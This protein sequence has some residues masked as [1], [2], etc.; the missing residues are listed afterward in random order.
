MNLTLDP[1][2]PVIGSDGRH[3][4]LS[5]KALFQ[6]ADTICDLAVQPHEK[7]ALMRLLIC[8]AQAALDGPSDRT[9]WS[10]SR[11]A[12]QGAANRYLEKWSTS[13][14]LFGNGPRFLQVPQLRLINDKKPK[15]SATKLD[16]TLASGNN[17]TVFDNAA[18]AARAVSPERLALTILAFQCFA[19][20]G[21]IGVA[22]WGDDE[23]PG[24]GTCNHAP[25]TPS[26]MLHTYIRGD[27]LLDTVHLNL[28]TRDEVA[29]LWP[30]G[31]GRP[32]W[33]MPVNAADDKKAIDNATGSYLGRLV[34][35]SRTIQLE[36]DGIHIILA[37]ALDYSQ[38][39]PSREA[40]STMVTKEGNRF[41][42]GAFLGRSIWRQLHMMTV[43]PRPGT[44]PI[45]G[46]LALRN[47][48]SN[49]G[50]TLWTGALVTDKAKIED[51]VEACYEIPPGMFTDAGRKLYEDGINLADQWEAALFHSLKEYADALKLKTGANIQAKRHFWTI[52]ETHVPTLLQLADSPDRVPDIKASK[53]ADLARDAAYA[54][55]ALVC[56]RLNSR[57]TQAF[58]F[59]LRRLSIS[60]PK[61]RTPA[62]IPA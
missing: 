47:L 43:K 30:M 7:I 14:E 27:T 4:D 54:S 59:G 37:N 33:E 39:E 26:A 18:R 2:I 50:C 17:A 21:R 57:Q 20:C 52:L 22:L 15:T 44:D 38:P 46:P 45:C 19:T 53:W 61:R 3:Q 12:I 13:F 1:W 8:I 9:A 56:S 58:A 16:L 42:M 24:K 41:P 40:A 6:S 10:W 48:A 55:Y 35:L 62:P 23:T 29:T 60:K 25:C 51:L 36:E 28:L 5:L 34:P 31:W 11:D 49:Q 32:L